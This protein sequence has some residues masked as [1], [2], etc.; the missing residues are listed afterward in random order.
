MIINIF[1]V[2]DVWGDLCS[3]RGGGWENYSEYTL[4]RFV[5]SLVSK[6]D[7]LMKNQKFPVGMSLWSIAVTIPNKFKYKTIY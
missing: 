1:G 5:D 7:I 3:R 4:T 2:E 6:T